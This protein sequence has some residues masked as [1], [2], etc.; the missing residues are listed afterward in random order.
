M[1]QYGLIARGFNAGRRAAKMN[2]A[3]LPFDGFGRRLALHQLI[4]QREFSSMVVQNLA[5]PISC[6]RYFEFAFADE[7]FAKRYGRR[8]GVKALDISSPRL[9][10]FWLAEKRAAHVTMVNADGNDIAVSRGLS[11]FLKNSDQIVLLDN[12][13]ATRLPFDEDCFDV[14][15]SISVIEHIN[16]EGDVRMV[17]EVS[18]VTRSG[19]LAVLT[20]PVKPTFENEYRETDPYGTQQPVP[21]KGFFFQRFYDVQS[22]RAR[23]LQ[24]HDCKEF[25]RRYYVESPP[26]WFAEYER[27]WIERGLEWT[28]NDPIFMCEHFVDAGSEHPTDRMGVCCLALEV[29]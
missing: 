4:A 13:N 2:L 23:I 21:G 8:N 29:R 27:T 5:N 3:G 25:A 10:P 14:T 28:V 18:R 12:V 16:G 1:S 17:S 20:F 19:G 22:I 24:S 6:V 7:V 11:Q 9:W 15:T 26:G